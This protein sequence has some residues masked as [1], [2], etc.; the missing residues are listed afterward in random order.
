MAQP[1][2]RTFS[3]A[4]L[5]I[6]VSMFM[7]VELFLGGFVGKIICGRYFSQMLALRLQ[8]VL[9]LGAY[10]IGGF[11]IGLMSPGIR[12][13]EPAVA[14]LISVAL[15]LVIAVFL[16]YTLMQMTLGKLLIG[17]GIAFILAYAG[18]YSGER[19]A[20]NVK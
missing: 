12:M 14:A 9:S 6:S 13:I 11:I 16:P 20:G 7:G 17:G 4:W 5:I 8:V 15:T 1:A 10:F 3:S 18:A 2:K 19:L